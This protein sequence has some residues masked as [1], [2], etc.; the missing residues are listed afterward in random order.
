MAVIQPAISTVL[1][2]VTLLGHGDGGPAVANTDGTINSQ[3]SANT[4][5]G[6]SIVSYTGT[7]SAATIGHGLTNQTPKFVIVKD[8]DGQS[9]GVFTTHQQGLA[10][11][12]LKCK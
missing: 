10:S 9:T 8:R 4:D 5:Y 12:F 7:G 1:I 11:T 2:H 6:F 3:V